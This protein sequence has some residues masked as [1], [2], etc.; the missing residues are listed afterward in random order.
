LRKNVSELKKRIEVLERNQKKLASRKPVA[1]EKTSTSEEDKDLA[2]VRITAKGLRSLRRK[3]KLTQEEYG[4]LLGVSGQAVYQWE[5]KEGPL[6]LRYKTREAYV[7]ARTMGA[8]EARAKL[9][10]IKPEILK[11]RK[12]GR[13][14]KDAS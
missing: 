8:R 4:V 1:T 10:E 11:K 7:E 14:R 5:R 13:P 12:R 2:R 9:A 6:P 3:L